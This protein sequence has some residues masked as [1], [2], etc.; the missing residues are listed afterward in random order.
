MATCFTFAINSEAMNYILIGVMS[1]FSVSFFLDYTN[2]KKKDLIL[3]LLLFSILLCSLRH[4]ESFRLSTILYSAMFAI[5]YLYY[6]QT[7]KKSPNFNNLYVKIIKFLLWIFFITLI[8]QQVSYFAHIPIFNYRIGENSVLKFNSL[9]SEPS[10]Y[11]KIILLLMMSFITLR[12]IE[13]GHTYNLFIN[14]KRD[15]SIWFIFFYQM[16]LSGSSFA[17]IL[18]ALFFIKFIKLKL[19]IPFIFITGFL[20]IIILNTDFKPIQRIIGLG[21]SIITLNEQKMFNAD[22]SGAFRI[23][24]T[25]YYIKKIDITQLDFWFGY[26]IDYIRYHLFSLS[27]AIDEERGLQVGLF[28][29]FIADFGLIPTILLLIFVFKYAIINKDK[30]DFIIWLL[31]AFDASFNSQLFWIAIILMSTNKI[32]KNNYLL[33]KVTV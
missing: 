33:Q 24:P 32:I 23:A 3:Y 2:I 14:Y 18:L 29:S 25:I 13:L 4:M 28:P 5:T 15:K 30:I 19:I 17:I 9:A 27:D 8:V 26:G 21:E 1:F 10:Y 7:I 22:E 16:I 6:W 31:I 12:E 11:S 20:G